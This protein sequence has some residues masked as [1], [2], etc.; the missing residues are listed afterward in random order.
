MKASISTFA[1][2]G[3]AAVVVVLAVLLLMPAIP[4]ALPPLPA[5]AAGAGASAGG[6]AAT[7]QPAVKQAAASRQTTP[8]V[9]AVAGL[10]GYRPPA[11]KPVAKAGPASAPPTASP[12]S[13][14]TYLGSVTMENGKPSWLLKDN[15]M[16][17]V[18]YLQLGQESG[19]WKLM[20]VR[21]AELLLESGGKLYRVTF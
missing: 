2:L 18:L 17:T 8:A 11:P 7:A 19:G 3:L 13:E 12:A 9:A 15:Q 16:N 5:P 1:E 10:F 20:E 21:A 4:R 14:L 6:A